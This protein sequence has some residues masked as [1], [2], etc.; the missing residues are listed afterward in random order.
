MTHAYTCNRMHHIL[1]SNLEQWASRPRLLPFARAHRAVTAWPT[2]TG[3]FDA[4]D[5]TGFCGLGP[6][7]TLQGRTRRPNTLPCL[8]SL[9]LR[10]WCY[11]V[12]LLSTAFGHIWAFH[13]TRTSQL[14]SDFDSPCRAW[15]CTH[16][17][18]FPCN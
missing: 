11:Y 4:V 5:S 17:Q 3:N 12:L 16:T 9:N 8:L 6:S 13:M 14:T 7:N 2:G 1:R 18:N 15:H 10:K